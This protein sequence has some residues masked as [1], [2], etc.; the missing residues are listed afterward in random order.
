MAR[1]LPAAF[2]SALLITGSA[3]AQ[4]QI[5]IINGDPSGQGF[6]DPTPAA[7]VGGNPGTT[8][9]AQRLNV[10]EAA[11]SIWEQTLK[12]KV[13]IRVLATFEPLGPN[14]LGSAGATFIHSDFPGAEFP[15]MWYPAALANHLSGEDLAVLETGDPTVPHIRARFSSQFAFYF[16]LDNNEPPGTVDLL[17]VLLHELGHGLGFA[18]FAN[19]STG[20]LFLGIPD[21]YSQYTLDVS[22][23]KIWNEM[24]DAERATSAVNFG[25]VS[26]SGINVARDVPSV[27]KPGVP[28]LTISSP[29]GLGPY[30]VGSASFGPAVTAAGVTGQIVVGLDPTD[31][32]SGASPTDGCGPLTNAAQVAG[33]IALLDRGTCAFTVKVKNAQNAGAIAV[34][35]ADNVL[36]EP[37]PGLGGADPT[38]TIPS[39]RI[40]LPAGNAIKTAAGPVTGTLQLDT[41]ILAGVDRVLG[42]MR[43]AALN[44][45]SPGSSISHYDAVA[46]PNQLMEP[47]INVDLT[48]SVTPPADLTTS[49]FTDI[50]WFSDGDGVPDGTDACL[51]SILTPTVQI[52]RCI[53]KAGNDVLANG[54]SVSDLVHQCGDPH[55]TPIRYLLCVGKVGRAMVQAKVLTPK[56]DLSLQLCALKSLFQ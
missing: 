53:S 23:S 52:G 27:L 33:N 32:A 17:P 54:C 6:N 56:E 42:L 35:I 4:G 16:G 47:A 38:I 10:F 41:S 20:T 43:L 48:S 39:G 31:A 40:T 5:I 36:A 13:D 3:L 21:V 7:P 1:H 25:K 50:G 45:V 49:L 26:W 11:A 34:V 2:L 22:T 44:P 28:T 51:G 19:E 29:A 55:R 14:V 37:P 8:L 24:T 9:G 30:E 18:N 46:F 12:P 15:G